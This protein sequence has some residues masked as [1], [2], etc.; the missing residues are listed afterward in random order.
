MRSNPFLNFIGIE[1]KAATH[2]EKIISGFGGFLAIFMI[3]QIS[4]M[5]LGDDAYLIVASMGAATVLLFAVPHG[6]LSQPWALFGG[7]L[8]SACVGVACAQL[9]PNTFAAAAAAV[10]IAITVMYYL[11]CVHPP[12]GATALSAVVGG[13]A[14]HEL[15]FMFVLTPVLINVLVIFFVALVFNYCFKWRRYPVALASTAQTARASTAPDKLSCEGIEYALRKVDSFIDVTEDDL[16][17][18]YSLANEFDSKPENR[19]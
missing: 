10:G 2:H 7:N 5:A 13:D 15:G 6:A 3:I 1:R 8:L 9:I 16:S 18:I 14:V 4:H 11:K 12:G 17:R 19:K